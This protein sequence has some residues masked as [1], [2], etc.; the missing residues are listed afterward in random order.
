M[1]EIQNTIFIFVTNNHK[2]YNMEIKAVNEKEFANSIKAERR[3][4]YI[5]AGHRGKG[6]GANGFLDEG[7]E[8]IALRDLVVAELKKISALVV[9]D[10]DKAQLS[11][12]VK[13]INSSCTKDD[14]CL[15]IH[16]NA[17]SSKSST[18]VECLVRQNSS[19]KEKALA[20]DICKRLSGVMQIKNRGVKSDNEGAHSRLAMCSDIRCTAV[21]LEVCFVSNED[22]VK[23]YQSNRY[24]VANAIAKALLSL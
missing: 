3:K 6:T 19:D 13:S 14:V 15:D 17:A 18:G 1:Y 4:Y 5:N 2:L 23:K 16:F 24:M 9:K 7:S 22:D 11:A 8:T 12:V 20:S 21:L 10:D